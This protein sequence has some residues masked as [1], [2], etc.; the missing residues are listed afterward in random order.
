[1]VFARKPRPQLRVAQ[2]A[3]GER[4]DGVGRRGGRGRQRAAEARAHKRAHVR[5]GARAAR[6]HA[7]VRDLRQVARR[8]GARVR[9]RRRARA[10]AAERAQRVQR[11]RGE[12]FVDYELGVELGVGGR[13]R[14]HGA[15]REE[16]RARGAF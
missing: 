11:V 6:E 13:R 1:V 9:A 8:G 4:D 5:K 10:H 7:R 15:R 12:E 2:R 14:G 3:G 16:A